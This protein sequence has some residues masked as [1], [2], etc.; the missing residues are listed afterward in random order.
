MNQFKSDED[1]EK[2]LKTQKTTYHMYEATKKETLKVRKKR[3]QEQG[4]EFPDSA[5]KE[6]LALI[7]TMQKDAHDKYI[8]AGGTEEE[9]LTPPAKTGKRPS[10]KELLDIVNRDSVE[11]I[12]K[13]NKELAMKIIEEDTTPT[14]QMYN[15]TPKPS[16]PEVKV[17]KED[18]TDDYVGGFETMDFNIKPTNKAGNIL[19][20]EIPI[21]SKGECYKH[22]KGRV[23]V[24]YLTAY[25]ENLIVSPNLYDSGTFLDRL[26][27]LKIMSNIFNPEDLLPG[28]RDAIILWL[29][30]SSYGVNF[31]ATATDAETGTKFETTIDLSKI[32]FKKFDLVGDENGYFDFTLPVTGDKIKF[33]FLTYRDLKSLEKLETDENDGIRKT[34]ITELIGEIEHILDDDKIERAMRLKITENLKALEEYRDSIE[35][36]ERSFSHAVTNKLI[37]SIVSINDITDRR[38]I[39]EYVLN[40]NVRDS[41]AL[42]KYITSNEPGLDFNVTVE[43]P[44]SLGGGSVSMFLTLDEYLFLVGE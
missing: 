21:P 11:S 41:S 39:G 12:Q 6:T 27:E 36:D 20:D 35:V 9:L 16:V 42:R 40:M 33:K 3:A 28:D 10:K 44:L 29:R 37:K 1:R 18:K 8:S 23:P 38:Y 31:P 30:A 17:Q 24:S 19:F 15:L 13:S 43:R 32:K 25:D 26:L 22:K 14:S 34:K 4:I 5:T 7:E 2:F